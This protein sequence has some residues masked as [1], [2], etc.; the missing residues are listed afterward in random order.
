MHARIAT[1]LMILVALSSRALAAEER[2]VY[3]PEAVR[4]ILDEAMPEL[5]QASERASDVIGRV[6]PDGVFGSREVELLRQ[7]MKL[8]DAMRAPTGW[9]FAGERRLGDVLREYVYVCRYANAPL[10]WRFTAIR[11]GIRWSLAEVRGSGQVDKLLAQ[12]TASGSG[13]KEEF[14][15]FCDEVVDK[16]VRGKVDLLDAIR[17]R[18]AG[19][20]LPRS[21]ITWQFRCLGA[22]QCSEGRLPATGSG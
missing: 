5:L 18:T 21:C 12:A 7:Q 11:K 2:S 9:D 22:P 13:E 14:L 1:G 10:V 16:M 17:N 3:S 4:K 20:S 6:A 15:G 8:P 19:H